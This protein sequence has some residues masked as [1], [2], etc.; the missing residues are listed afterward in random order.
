[1]ADALE[2]AGGP[3]GAPHSRLP[4]LIAYA[5]LGLVVVGGALSFV[6]VKV[7]RDPPPPV[8]WSAWQPTATLQEPRLRQIA[9]HVSL[10]YRDELGKR[11]ARAVATNNSPL[12]I[13]GSVEANVFKPLF[14]VT[15]A[16]TAQALL[17]GPGPVPCAVKGEPAVAD[18]LARAEAV[19]LSLYTLKYVPQI[20]AVLVRMP[21][22]PGEKDNRVFVLVRT[23]VTEELERPLADTLGPGYPRTLPQASGNPVKRVDALTKGR[24]FGFRE[25]QAPDGAWVMGLSEA[26]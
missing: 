12:S 22:L 3:G 16:D 4:F 23:A 7:W 6:Y 15:K 11:F 14:A 9:T 26:P 21:P 1:M 18:A 2:S 13:V 19:E 8:P 17:C 24:M 5:L 10:T 20:N 25:F